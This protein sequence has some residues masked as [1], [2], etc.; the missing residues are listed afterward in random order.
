MIRI[1]LMLAVILVLGSTGFAQSPGTQRIAAVV[2]DQVVTVQDLNERLRLI[3]ATSG[4]QNSQQ[5][6][7]RL[8]PQVLRGLIEETLQLQ[9]ADRLGIAVQPQ[10]IDRAL[11]NIAKRNNLTA[12][13]LREF[14]ARSGISS[15]TLARQIRAQIAWV[16]VV[17]QQIR[18]RVQVTVDQLD[19]A[20]EESRQNQGQP[21]YLLSEIVLPVDSPAQEELVRQDAAR[22]VQTVREGASF[23]ALARQVSVAASAEQGGDVGWVPASTVPGELLPTLEELAPGEISDPVRSNVGYHIFQ[24]RDRRLARAPLAGQG[25]QVEVQL[26]QVVFPVGGGTGPDLDARRVEAAERRD[27]LDTCA[28]VVA[29]AEELAAPAS[30]DLGWLKIGDLPADLG[31]AVLA[32]PVAEISPPLEGPSGIYLI[33]VCDRRDPAGLVPEREQISERL[34]NERLDRLARRYLRDLRKQAFVEVRL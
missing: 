26:A 21:E 6:R 15:E 8:V 9:E 18:P 19:M 23:E 5:A 28:D 29:L 22:L 33:M 10:E 34:Q 1:G 17:N 11:V 25:A 3:M 31:D 24:L 14:I 4:I 27:G 12:E 30:G 16:K 7:A 2:N 32:L 20:V 13:Q